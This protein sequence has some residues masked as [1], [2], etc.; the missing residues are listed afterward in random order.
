MTTDYKEGLNNK[1]FII[2]LKFLAFCS[3]QSLDIMTLL[4]SSK[5]PVLCLLGGI[6][7]LKSKVI[8]Y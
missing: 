1:F 7:S 8:D 5:F 2:K 3:L 4:G 6:Y